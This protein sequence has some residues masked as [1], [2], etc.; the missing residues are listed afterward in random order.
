MPEAPVAV[1]SPSHLCPSP[2][3]TFSFPSPEDSGPI[4]LR[5]PSLDSVCAWDIDERTISAAGGGGGG[6]E[7]ELCAFSW[8]VVYLNRRYLLA[9]ESPGRGFS[10]THLS[11]GLDKEAAGI[12]G[13]P[14]REPCS[15]DLEPSLLG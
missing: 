3:S 1:R 5:A 13:E 6:S 2:V 14:R 15:I 12:S 8:K 7:T 4:P 11:S 9:V 10:E